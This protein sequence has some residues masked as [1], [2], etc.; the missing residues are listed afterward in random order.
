MI[1]SEVI[2]HIKELS[3]AD[4]FLLVEEILKSIREESPFLELNYKQKVAGGAALMAFA[5]ILDEKEAAIFEE[6]VAEARKI[7]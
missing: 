3:L 7:G 2:T 6:A 1:K 4:R 5:G